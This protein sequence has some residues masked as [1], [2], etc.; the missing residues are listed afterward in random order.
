M[1]FK[2]S[3]QGLCW[4]HATLASHQLSKFC[5]EDIIALSSCP[6]RV[7]LEPCYI[8]DTIAASNVCF[9][10]KKRG[11]LTLSHWEGG[12]KGPYLGT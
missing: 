2:N 8:K 11:V 5:S 9:V 10:Y 3:K 4:R 7:S 6:F 1:T 12:I